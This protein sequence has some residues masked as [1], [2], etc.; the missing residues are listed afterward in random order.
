MAFDF[1]HTTLIFY[2]QLSL[3]SVTT[4]KYFE[5]SLSVTSDSLK[6]CVFQGEIPFLIS[7]PISVVN[8]SLLV[9][10]YSLWLF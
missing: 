10:F 2:V 4:P 6:M 5:L 9:K 3:L 1:L 8:P 7:S